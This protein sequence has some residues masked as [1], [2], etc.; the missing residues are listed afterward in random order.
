MNMS[1][2]YDNLRA[3][4]EEFAQAQD[5]KRAKEDALQIDAEISSLIDRGGYELSDILGDSGNAK[6][7]AEIMCAMSSA[8]LFPTDLNM[9]R[10]GKAAAALCRLNLSGVAETYLTQR[11]E[12]SHGKYFDSDK[13]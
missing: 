7:K 11:E 2:Y 12:M 3:I 5:A 8:L 4:K 13:K 1:I 10:L 6:A 9:I